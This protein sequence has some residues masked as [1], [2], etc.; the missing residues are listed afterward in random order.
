MAAALIIYVTPTGLVTR[1]VS[2]KFVSKSGY[3]CTEAIQGSI[4]TDIDIAN[5]G[6]SDDASANKS[7]FVCARRSARSTVAINSSIR[8]PLNFICSSQLFFA[9]TALFCFFLAAP[10]KL[11]H[12]FSKVFTRRAVLSPHRGARQFLR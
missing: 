12:S 9:D 4:A 11:H 7:S 2:K 8:V 3:S 6:S 5:N 10:R 1:F